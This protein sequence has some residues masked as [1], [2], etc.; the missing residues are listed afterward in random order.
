M[1]FKKS[2]LMATCLILAFSICSHGNQSRSAVGPA[3][4]LTVDA[5]FPGGNI[6]VDR[7]EG[8][9]VFLKPDL[10]DTSTWWFYWHFRVRAAAGRTIKFQ[11]AGRSPIG[12]RGP[13][14]PRL[15]DVG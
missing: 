13:A 5:D 14:S 1:R 11:F 4:A 10:R 8:D 15:R 3:E 7:I 12:T 9:T 2:A 6:V